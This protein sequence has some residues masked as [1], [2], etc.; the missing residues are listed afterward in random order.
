MSG[1]LTEPNNP[2]RADD[3]VRDKRR[4]AP[5]LSSVTSQC[6]ASSFQT[7]LR[8]RSAEHQVAAEV[9]VVGDRLQVGKDLRLI[10]VRAT[11]RT[12]RRERE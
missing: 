2:T 9:E 11:P 3:D 10:R 6:S 4:S 1:Y 5:S 12:V 8:T 7:S